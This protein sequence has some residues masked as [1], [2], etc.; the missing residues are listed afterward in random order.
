MSMSPVSHRF[1]PLTDDAIQWHLVLVSVCPMKDLLGF[2]QVQYVVPV[3]SSP[4][5][6]RGLIPNTPLPYWANLKAYRYQR[7]SQ[8]LDPASPCRS[9]IR[10]KSRAFPEPT[11]FPIIGVNQPMK[12]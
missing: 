12:H 1:S 7:F 6:L 11:K 5:P 4:G 2:Y 3:A 8:H 10:A 9:Y